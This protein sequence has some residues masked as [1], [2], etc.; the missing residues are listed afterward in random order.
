MSPTVCM[1]VC[2]MN[3]MYVILQIRGVTEAHVV[4]TCRFAGQL[5]RASVL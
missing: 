2:L 4:D 5:T 1:Y 3:V